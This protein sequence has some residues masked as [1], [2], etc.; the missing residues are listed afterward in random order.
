VTKLL[1]LRL[2]KQDNWPHWQVVA[3]IFYL[4]VQKDPEITGALLRFAIQ[5]EEA[6]WRGFA[7]E[8]VRAIKDPELPAK[9]AFERQRAKDLRLELPGEL[10]TLGR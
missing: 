6:E 4:G 5:T 10:R 2:L 9:L 7:I 1:A 8:A 3:V